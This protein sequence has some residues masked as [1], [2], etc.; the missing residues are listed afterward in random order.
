MAATFSWTE[1][2]SWKHLSFPDTALPPQHLRT[3]P[4]AVANCD[5]A[6]RR[7]LCSR[8]ESYP[9]NAVRGSWKRSSVGLQS[10][11]TPEMARRTLYAHFPK[12]FPCFCHM[13][14]G[15]PCC[16]KGWEP[17]LWSLLSS[18]ESLVWPKR[19]LYKRKAWE[20]SWILLEVFGF[21]IKKQLEFNLLFFSSF[22]SLFF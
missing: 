12:R 9:T 11:W 1:M 10:L 20:L 8:K 6:S 21:T 19:S 16:Q 2:R 13:A 4:P 7:W 14:S 3:L 17:L 15:I 22:S 18:W 5:V